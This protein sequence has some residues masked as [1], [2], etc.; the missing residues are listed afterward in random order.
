ML[1]LVAAEID[2]FRRHLMSLA[3]EIP[4][5][6]VIEM[7]EDVFLIRPRDFDTRSTQLESLQKSVAL[8]LGA[9]IHGN[10]WGSL[11]VINLLL[12]KIRRKTVRLDVPLGLFLG[13]TR[14]ALQGQRF[15]DCDLN[16]SFF[17]QPSQDRPNHQEEQRAREIATLLEKTLFFVDFHQ[18]I[19]KTKS[20][21]FIFGYRAP[22]ITF[23]RLIHPYLPIV[24]HWGTKFSATGL[25]SD[26]FVNS[27]G[28]LGITMEIGA[29][30]QDYDP[31]QAA[32][33]FQCALTAL[34]YASHHVA[35]NSP[36]VTALLHAQ[37]FGLSNTPTPTK[38]NGNLY[39]WSHIE[40]WPLSD[41]TIVDLQPGLI[42]FA[43]LTEGQEYG[44]R[45]NQPIKAPCSGKVLFP[46]YLS[47]SE[48]RDLAARG[49]LP[50]E[51]IRFLKPI[52]LDDLPADLN[53][54]S[55]LCNPAK[56][57]KL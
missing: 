38:D 32:L 24:T 35:Q 41:G 11:W 54:S 46:K 37:T 39:T 45:G 13:N 17:L 10:E 33:G 18:T 1:Q 50:R 51:L 25:C 22:A 19:Q 43:D 29:I 31:M 52:T 14:A 28:G 40:P 5:L 3:A 20:S 9:L 48:Q 6:Q 55:E 47:P 15:L 23:A 44:R 2:V 49:Q 56:K 12:E 27:R 7:A 8:S 16:R 34:E 36:S 57:P 42:N 4:D 30:A 26:E 21:F 53:S